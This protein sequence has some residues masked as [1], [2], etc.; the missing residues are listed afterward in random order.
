MIYGV[1]GSNISATVK[2]SKISVLA[3]IWKMPIVR[4]HVY[5][6]VNGRQ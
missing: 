3:T 1:Q 6:S 2:K 5:L 4:K